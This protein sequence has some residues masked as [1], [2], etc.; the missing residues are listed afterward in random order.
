[1]AIESCGGAP[2]NAG[3]RDLAQRGFADRSLTSLLGPHIDGISQEALVA[4]DAMQ[5]TVRATLAKADSAGACSA[6]VTETPG[7]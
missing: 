3:R 6:Q 1:M 2:P 4:I 7:H 5:A